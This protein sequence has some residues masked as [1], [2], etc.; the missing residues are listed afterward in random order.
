[1]RHIRAAI[2]FRDLALERGRQSTRS[3]PEVCL[4]KASRNLTRISRYFWKHEGAQGSLT[5]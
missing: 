4:Q 1:M 3:S 5:A 2:N